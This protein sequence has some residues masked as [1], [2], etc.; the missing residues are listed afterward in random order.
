MPQNGN[1]L[2]NDV[3]MYVLVTELLLFYCC[4]FNIG[5]MNKNER[6]ENKKKIFFY[7]KS[8]I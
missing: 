5:G 6:N 1:T 4:G 7:K 8:N 2:L 3:C